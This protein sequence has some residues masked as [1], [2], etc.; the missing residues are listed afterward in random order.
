MTHTPFPTYK[1]TVQAIIDVATI[2]GATAG[3]PLP[4]TL[5]RLDLTSHADAWRHYEAMEAAGY[6]VQLVGHADAQ[7]WDVCAS[8]AA[9]ATPPALPAELARDFATFVEAWRYWGSQAGYVRALWRDE[10]R[11]CYHVGPPRAGGQ[12]HF[13][14]GGSSDVYDTDGV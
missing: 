3:Q 11:S 13:E 8:V 2:V 5:W 4:R 14:R 6:R 12:D 10:T 1:K 9:A 7:T